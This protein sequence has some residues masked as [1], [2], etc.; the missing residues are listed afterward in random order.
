MRWTIFFR[1]G[2]IALT[3]DSHGKEE[4]PCH[5]RPAL[6]AAL[7]EVETNMMGNGRMASPPLAEGG[8]PIA[9]TERWTST[10]GHMHVPTELVC[11]SRHALGRPQNC[12]TRDV[13]YGRPQVAHLYVTL[14]RR[15]CRRRTRAVGVSVLVGP[16]V[17]ALSAGAFGIGNGMHP[18]VW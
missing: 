13:W 12:A 14:P 17:H 11:T 1:N 7:V 18:K 16:L 8:E 5:I 3:P 15:L 6:D 9:I 10:A 2:A 4:G